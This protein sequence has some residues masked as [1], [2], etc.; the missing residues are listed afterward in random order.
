[1]DMENLR[2]ISVS[3]DGGTLVVANSAIKEIP[4]IKVYRVEY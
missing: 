1:V 4:T 3:M 2:A